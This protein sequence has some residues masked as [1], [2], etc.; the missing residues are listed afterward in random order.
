MIMIHYQKKIF[1]NLKNTAQVDR[2]SESPKSPTSPGKFH[3]FCIDQFNKNFTDDDNI[4]SLGNNVNSP[5]NSPKANKNIL[6]D[7]GFP[8]QIE[9]KNNLMSKKNLMSTLNLGKQESLQEREL[10]ENKETKNIIKIKPP[11]GD[12]PILQEDFEAKTPKKR[13]SFLS[14]YS[15][16]SSQTK[17]R[18]STQETSSINNFRVFSKLK[19]QKEGI[20]FGIGDLIY[21]DQRGQ[22]CK[23]VKALRKATSKI[24]NDLD[25]IT[26][27]QRFQELDKLKLLLLNKNQ[28]ML[29]NL[30]AKPEIFIDE[31]ETIET[32]PGLEISKN[33]KALNEFD[34]QSMLDLAIYY[35]NV[36]NKENEDD[37]D[38]R[39]VRL[40]DQDMKEYFGV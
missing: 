39:L 30:I 6:S 27:L 18:K 1:I 13:Q 24:N 37:L 11:I 22:F 32:T 36:K 34:D 14:K 7:E 29:F 19:S 8:I 40:V 28:L 5:S 20:Q 3:S 25:I 12:I 31:K 17:K 9:P 4:K 16:F 2:G 26:V 38:S 35:N 10:S 21:K 23:K 33:L 15:G